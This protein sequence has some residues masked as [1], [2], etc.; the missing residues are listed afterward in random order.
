MRTHGWGLLL[1]ALLP[2][3][4]SANV[5]RPKDNRTLVIGHPYKLDWFTT[6][7]M[8]NSAR[9]LGYKIKFQDLKSSPD[10]LT[11][12]RGVDALLVP[13]G[14]DIHPSYYT[15]NTLPPEFLAAIEKFKRYYQSTNEGASRDPYEFNVYRTYFSSPEFA[16]L[17][18]LGIC[19]GMQMMAVSKGIPLVQDLK[20]EYGITNRRN[21]FDRFEVVEG[22]SLISEMFPSGAEWGFKNHHQN[23]RM[24]YLTRYAASHAEVKITATSQR[25]RILEAMEMTDR[26]ALGVQFHPEKSFPYVKHQIF[27]WLLTSA[28]ERTHHGEIK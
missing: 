16:T 18:A 21:R 20:A 13:G 6:F 4:A 3:A 24:D 19:R 27:K 7:R 14:A 22:A 2:L 23:P 25:G 12:L 10:A 15:Y 8:K 9:L 17:P 28:C 5:C 11:G 1:L 26:P